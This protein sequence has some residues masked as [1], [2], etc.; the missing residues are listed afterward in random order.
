MM[1][2]VDKDCK[3]I[4]A[5][6][7]DK[8]LESIVNGAGKQQKKREKNLFK[9][10]DVKGK[11]KKIAGNVKENVM[12]LGKDEDGIE[13]PVKEEKEIKKD[14]KSGLLFNKNFLRLGFALFF[15]IAAL[16]FVYGF[17]NGS[18]SF[19]AGNKKSVEEKSKKIKEMPDVLQVS[20]KDRKVTDYAGFE[21]ARKQFETDADTGSIAITDAVNK[22]KLP[23]E[24]QKVNG[25]YTKDTSVGGAGGREK[26]NNENKNDGHVQNEGNKTNTPVNENRQNNADGNSYAAKEQDFSDIF[27]NFSSSAQSGYSPSYIKPVQDSSAQNANSG[28]SDY[29]AALREQNKTSY[30]KTNAQDKKKG[31]LNNADAPIG[32][33]VLQA[34]IEPALSPYT[35]YQGTVIP[36]ILRTAINSDLPGMIVAQIKRDV[37]DTVSGKF[38]I[39]PA[40]STVVGSYDSSV[41]F[42]QQRVLIVWQRIIR[43]DG[44]SIDLRGM[45]GIDLKG[46]AGYSDKVDNH[47]LDMLKMTGLATLLDVG[48]KGVEVLTDTVNIPKLVG[49]ALNSQSQA[50]YN[51]VDKTLEKYLEVQPTLMVREG[52]EGNIFV[53][54]DI[55]IPPYK[56]N[57]GRQK[58]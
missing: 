13:K 35:V 15:S 51:T 4:L 6:G 2:K 44:S 48:V 36:I 41:T 7:E 54:K 45:Q 23:K 28:Q 22:E 18:N 10:T 25:N 50:M 42:G 40:G 49:Q 46:Q 31:F 39:L 38:L 17:S 47:Y 58:R 21:S 27:V 55:I 52:F 5:I 30:E 14:D 29:A 32:N 8:K 34:Q 12:M 56:I 1:N 16:A 20:D 24:L 33:Y 3:Y 11:L 43:P 57:T 37:Y 53:N 9:K 19:L 26:N